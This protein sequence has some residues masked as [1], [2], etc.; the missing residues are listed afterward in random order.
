MAARVV[1]WSLA[2]LGGLALW[3]VC[4]ALFISSL[5][6]SHNQKVLYAQFRQQL[7]GLSD[8]P[9]PLGNNISPGAP[10]AVLSMPTAGL[11]RVVVVEG[12]ASGDLTK[13]PGHKRD[14]VLPG[15]V[16]TSVLYGR[17][18]MF[19][20]PFKH[21]AAAQPGDQITVITGQ[22]TS[23]YAVE[24]VRRAGDP[25]PPLLATGEARL[26][27]VTADGS[28][29]RSGWAPNA[30]VYV[31]AKLV[32]HAFPAPGG[33]PAAVPEAETALHGDSSALYTL[34]L[35]LAL[36][37]AAVLGIV[38]AAERWGRWQAWLVGVPIMLAVLWGASETAVQLLPNLT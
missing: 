13:G 28:G 14:T 32:G 29:W 34:V 9:A 4:F 25:F 19:G 15:Q 24:D 38:W 16:G 7:S 1:A 6:E 37:I 10:V 17:Q 26:T 20:G 23:H 11:D 22:G 2:A 8:H 31:D 36:M 21:I 30:A 33:R 12:T 18:A 5:Q 35:W 3:L 27:L